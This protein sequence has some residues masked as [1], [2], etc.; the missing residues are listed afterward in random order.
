MNKFMR[1]E[2]HTVSTCCN[3]SL[4]CYAHNRL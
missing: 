3:W 4:G 1:T 2:S